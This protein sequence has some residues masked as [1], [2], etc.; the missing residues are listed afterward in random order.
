MVDSLSRSLLQR[1]WRSRDWK[2]ETVRTGEN[3]HQLSS[4]VIHPDS[5]LA[6]LSAGVSKWRPGPGESEYLGL[7]PDDGGVQLRPLLVLGVVVDLHLLQLSLSVP[8]LLRQR[9][10]VL[11][12]LL[13]TLL[14][15]QPHMHWPMRS[16][17]RDNM[18][19]SPHLK[20]WNM[21]FCWRRSSGKG[22][23]FCFFKM[24]LW[25]FLL[26]KQGNQSMV[27]QLSVV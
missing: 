20:V 27:F 16:F 18:S 1:G 22:F 25:E 4:S 5:Q 21:F 10:G 7:Q 23:F 15:T 14:N 12:L 6:Q 11:G 9:L 24:N 17:D 2:T 8:Q 26:A 3:I 19:A 13:Q